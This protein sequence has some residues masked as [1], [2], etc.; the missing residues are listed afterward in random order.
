MKA[1][2]F[3]LSSGRIETARNNYDGSIIARILTTGTTVHIH[4]DGRI[5]ITLSNNCEVH[6]SGEGKVS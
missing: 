1:G 6:I 3:V 5:T 2:E 4:A